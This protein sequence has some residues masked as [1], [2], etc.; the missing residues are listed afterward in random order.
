[1]NDGRVR[2]TDQA[3]GETGLLVFASPVSDLRVAYRVLEGSSGLVAS[4]GTE[5]NRL[6]RAFSLKLGLRSEARGHLCGLQHISGEEK[7]QRSI[8]TFCFSLHPIR[9]L[10]AGRASRDHSQIPHEGRPK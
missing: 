9:S 7:E 3:F 5:Q 4:T 2:Y 6:S 10:E 1:M 8:W